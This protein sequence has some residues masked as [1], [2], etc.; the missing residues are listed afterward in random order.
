MQ[1][2]YIHVGTHKT[3]TTW[4]QH[5]LGKNS[6][7]LNDFGFYYPTSG[8]VTQAQHRLGQAIFNRSSPNDKLEG[9]PVWERFRREVALTRYENIV[10]SSEEF[11]WVQLPKLIKEF[12]PDVS[13]RTIIYLRRQDDYIESLY[14]QQIRDYQPRLKMTIQEYLQSNSLRFLDYDRLIKQWQAAS[15]QVHVRA[16]DKKFMKNGDVGADFLNVL[17][18][19]NAEGFDMPSGPVIDNKT[20]LSV[21]AL[22]FVRQCNALPMAQATHNQLVNQV[23]RLDQIAS[24]AAGPKK[25][26]RLL[27]FETRSRIMNG[28]AKMNTAIS[29]AHPDATGLKGL[30]APVADDA[31]VFNQAESFN[32]FD[33]LLKANSLVKIN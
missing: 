18:I 14:G 27:D 11:E 19:D 33:V 5:Y 12:M 20:N 15:D 21:E 10:I 4:L 30:F 7:R 8:R 29:A 28:Y 1:N 3:A 23:T 22:E 17:G 31:L 9:I 16:F 26:I 6:D 13:I 32:K 25:R 2:L 24:K